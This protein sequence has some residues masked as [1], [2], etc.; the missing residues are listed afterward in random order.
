MDVLENLKTLYRGKSQKL[1]M[2]KKRKGR[3]TYSLGIKKKGKYIP[4]P[5]YT[6]KQQKDI[7]L[8]RGKFKKLPALYAIK[9]KKGRVV[10]AK[11]IG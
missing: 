11:R 6:K 2:P 8:D 9:K 5:K 10:K 1:N 4:I 7:L 3:T